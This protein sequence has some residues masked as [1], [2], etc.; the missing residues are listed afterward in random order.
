MKRSVEGLAVLSSLLLLGSSAW[1]QTAPAS[2]PVIRPAT[3]PAMQFPTTRPAATRPAPDEP[4]FSVGDKK[5]TEGDL[6]KNLRRYL[7]TPPPGQPGPTEDQITNILVRSRAQLINMIVDEQI[8]QAEAAKHQVELTPADIE[9]AI[10]KQIQ[11]ALKSQGITREELAD[12]MKKSGTT[13][14]ERIASLKTS[15]QFVQQT[16]REKL[17]GVLFKDIEVTDEEVKNTFETTKEARYSAQ[18]RASH[19]LVRANMND[20]AAKETAKKKAEEL[21]AKVQ[22]PGADFAAVAKESSEDPGS[23][24]QGGDLG[25]FPRKG[26]MVEPFAAAAFALKPGEISGLVESQFGFHIIQRTR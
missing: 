10:D 17:A 1:A 14:E 25:F 23:K 22:A 9:T 2:R 26:R 16:T 7:G 21:L 11:S 12:R 5:Y 24:P 6:E 15:P 19:I 8:L 13:I 3:R 20:T 4:A 18:V